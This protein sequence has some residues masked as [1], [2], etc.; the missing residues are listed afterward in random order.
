[1]VSK[2]P[3]TFGWSRRTGEE[4]EQ[5]GRRQVLRV[6]FLEFEPQAA[7][8]DPWTELGR[9]PAVLYVVLGVLEELHKE[10]AGAL[11]LHGD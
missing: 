2:S 3:D 6:G 11:A 7:L 5:D 9:K 8:F 4:T 10:D 1:M